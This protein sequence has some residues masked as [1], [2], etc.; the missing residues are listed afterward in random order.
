MGRWVKEFNWG[1]NLAAPGAARTRNRA[2]YAEIHD[3]GG[4]NRE[5]SMSDGRGKEKEKG[6]V[7][8]HT[9]NKALS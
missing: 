5:N 6:E 3:I 9:R 2:F 1:G 8:P 4:D 7:N